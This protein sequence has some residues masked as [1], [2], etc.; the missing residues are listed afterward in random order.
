M[1]NKI[2]EHVKANKIYIPVAIIALI[3]VIGSTSQDIQKK[4]QE[5][6][7]PANTPAQVKYYEKPTQTPV[8]NTPTPTIPTDPYEYLV[9]LGK[10]VAGGDA[11]SIT[12]AKN[13]DGSIDVYNNIAMVPEIDSDSTMD[14]YTRRWVTKFIKGSYLS[15]I[16]IRYVLVTVS[17]I[18]TGRP[19]TRVG[20]GV[21]QAEK[22]SNEDWDGLG[23]T[24]LCD[25]INSMMQNGDNLDPD[26]PGYDPSNWIF[27]KNC[28]R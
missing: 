2:V 10:D 22:I 25:V 5:K 12:I 1:F 20:M 8:P 21:K 15:G 27:A 9:T 28:E 11:S 26:E 6:V 13:T 24:M 14:L 7:T 3:G 16:N 23:S 18:G 17:F 4:N 19:A